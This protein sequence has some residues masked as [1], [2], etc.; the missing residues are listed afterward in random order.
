MSTIL[1]RVEEYL[2]LA[3]AH[4][5]HTYARQADAVGLGVATIHRLRRGDPAGARAVAAIC[6][7]YHVEFAE[8]FTLTHVRAASSEVAA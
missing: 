6:S 3:N 4:G 5:H 2:A 7:T 8:L 1:L